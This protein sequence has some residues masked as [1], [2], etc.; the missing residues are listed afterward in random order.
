MPFYISQTKLG[1]SVPA[2]RTPLTLSFVNLAHVP[3]AA[4]PNK[5]RASHYHR[6]PL[7]INA[8]ANESATTNFNITPPGD[9][10]ALWGDDDVLEVPSLRDQLHPR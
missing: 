4:C 9:S 8:G 10:N 1:P 5:T 2:L 6:K 7:R 3:A